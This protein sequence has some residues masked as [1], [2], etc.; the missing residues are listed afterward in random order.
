MLMNTCKDLIRK[1]ASSRDTF[2]KQELWE[3]LKDNGQS[4]PNTMTCM[5][6]QMVEAGELFRVSR[7]KYALSTEGKSTFHAVLE[8][9]EREVSQKLK[10]K[11]PFATFCIYNGRSL[12]SLQHHMS[13]NNTTYIETERYAVDSVFDYLRGEGYVVWNNPT[14]DFIYMYVNL[15]DQCIIVKPLVTEAPTEKLDGIA[16]PTLEKVLVD[17]EKD[18]CFDYLHG[19]ESSRMWENARLLYNINQT[20]LIRYAQRR[21]LKL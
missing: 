1:F 2:G 11:F 13:E 4:T 6:S 21:G 10:Q 18:P 20:R 7:G 9:K 15:K 14:A 19:T 16:V 5:L 12:S 17:I 8:D 3:W